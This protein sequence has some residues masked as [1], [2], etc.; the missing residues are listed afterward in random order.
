M[1]AGEPPFQAAIKGAREIGF[2]IISMTLSL[3]AVFIPVMFMGGVIGRLLHEFAVTISAADPGLRFRLADPDPHAG[4]PL[5][6]IRR[7]AERHGRLYSAVR[8]TCSSALLAGYRYSLA[9][10]MAHPRLIL[11]VF[12]ATVLATAVST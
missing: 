8:I 12:V 11:L 2:T 5:S 4:Q 6:Q 3:I 10:A 1:E 9:W 7:R